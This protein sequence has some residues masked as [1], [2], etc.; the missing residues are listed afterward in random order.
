MNQPSVIMG[1]LGDTNFL[2]S[3]LTGPTDP[4]FLK[5]GIIIFFFSFGRPTPFISITD[6]YTKEEREEIMDYA[7]K[8]TE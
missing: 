4:F 8:R 2:K 1:G 3:R 5:M 6:D 7:S